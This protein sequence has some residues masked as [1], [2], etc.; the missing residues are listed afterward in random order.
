[1]A[2][3]IQ[4]RLHSDLGFSTILAGPPTA[5]QFSGILTGIYQGR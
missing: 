3:L 5:I 1:M 4:F 2:G